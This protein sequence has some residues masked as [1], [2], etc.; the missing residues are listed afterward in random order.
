MWQIFISKS[1]NAAMRN[2]ILIESLD[3]TLE[4]DMDTGTCMK[5]PP[6]AYL[7]LLFWLKLYIKD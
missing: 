5:W 2:I 3:K 6:Q 1:V 4:Y 7:D